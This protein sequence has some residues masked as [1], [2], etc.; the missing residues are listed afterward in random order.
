MSNVKPK[1]LPTWLQKVIQ[2]R[3][4]DDGQ[5]YDDNE[6]LVA[7]FH[8]DK[9]PEGFQYWRD[10]ADGIIPTQP[11][12]LQ[13]AQQLTITDTEDVIYINNFKYDKD[14]KTFTIDHKD[15]LRAEGLLFHRNVLPKGVII[16]NYKTGL[17]QSFYIDRIQ[18]LDNKINI[19]VSQQQE[20]TP[21]VIVYN[22]INNNYCLTVLIDTKASI[23]K[24]S[25]TT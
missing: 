6:R 12:H 19:P 14:T 15:L 4:E 8:F 16:K 2:I 24:M 11:N 9:T 3:T 13:M 18:T 20:D 23:Y 25:K 22:N 21:H 1:D 5:V 7:M 10:I 17:I